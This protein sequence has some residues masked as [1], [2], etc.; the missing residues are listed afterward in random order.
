MIIFSYSPDLNQFVEDAVSTKSTS[1][2]LPIQIDIFNDSVVSVPS[3]MEGFCLGIAED[4]L[5][6]TDEFL[7]KKSCVVSRLPN[8]DEYGW[9]V[10]KYGDIVCPSISI[11][12]Q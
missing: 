6:Y 8:G 9:G 10:N 7:H 2:P 12:E 3:Y 1:I 4:F 5:D 11:V